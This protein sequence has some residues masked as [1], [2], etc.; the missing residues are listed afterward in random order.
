MKKQRIIAAI[1]FGT[2][3]T[4][5]AWTTIEDRHKDPKKR[6][7]HFR[8]RWQ[9]LPTPYPKNLT[10]L[11]L[12]DK[13]EVV[14]WGYEARRKWATHAARGE[15]E[16]YEYVSSFKMSLA[17]EKS[18]GMEEI[19][20]GRFSPEKSRQLVTAYLEKIYSAAMEEIERGGY[21]SDEVRWCLTV[22]AIWDDY[23]KQLMREAAVAAGLPEDAKRLQLVIEPEAAA[24][25]ARVSGVRTVRASGRRASLMTKGSRFLVADCGGGTIDITAYR[26]DD[27]NR[28]EEIG[29]EC[30]GKY[31]SEYV[32]Q[33]FLEQVLTKR[34]GSFDVI[35]RIQSEAPSAFLELLNYWEKAKLNITTTESD[36][37]FLQLP[38][39]IY[40]LLSKEERA[41]LGDQQDGIADAI[42]VRSS[43]ARDVFESVVPSIL[44]LVDKQLAEMR[45]QRR[46]APGK[47][48]VILVG[49][50]GNSPYLQ[51]RLQ[52]H[53]ADRADILVP[54]DPQLAVLLGAVHYTYDPQTKSRRTK[55][56]Y[57]C[58]TVAPFREGVDPEEY[59]LS[60]PYGVR[61]KNRFSTFVSA[62]QSVPVDEEVTQSFSPL[63]PDQKAI[64]FEL[65]KSDS[66]SPRYTTDLGCEKIGEVTVDLSEV[67]HLP[68]ERRSVSLSMMFGEVQIRVSALVKATQKATTAHIRFTPVE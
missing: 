10:A 22:P 7:V 29:R 56:T 27:R 3:G 30:G 17:A 51:E 62:G 40:V 34:L 26:T 4:G 52:E 20:G 43:E 35:E 32:N 23:Q 59:K 8:T 50:F 12:N 5:Y 6:L 42:V 65:Y 21:S 44:A 28:L 63:Y 38:A 46:N 60:L 48:L 1:D 67:M 41:T 53:L 2:H 37:I 68:F 24:Y 49:G 25:H 16:G 47:E 31:G 58:N 19:S 54:P 9:D 66:K 61:C 45:V 18:E 13:G 36:D 33:A 39:A 64:E 14:S 57:G 11:L 55:Y 15:T